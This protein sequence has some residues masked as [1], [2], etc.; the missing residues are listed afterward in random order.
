MAKFLEP[1]M[2]QRLLST[3]SFL[4]IKDEQLSNQILAFIRDRLELSMI[5]VEISLFDLSENLGGIVALER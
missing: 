1:W 4:L 5:E 3:N 2:A